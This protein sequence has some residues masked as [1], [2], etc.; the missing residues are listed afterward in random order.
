ML[1]DHTVDPLL[2]ISE[3]QKASI[4]AVARRDAL[5]DAEKKVNHSI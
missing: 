3:E 2:E 1:L 4:A 5:K